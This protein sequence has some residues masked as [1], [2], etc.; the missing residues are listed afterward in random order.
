MARL[1]AVGVLVALYVC[2]STCTS[3]LQFSGVNSGVNFVEDSHH[4]AALGI[5]QRALFKGKSLFSGLILA[6]E[7]CYFYLKQ[8]NLI[9]WMSVELNVSVLLL[10]C[11]VRSTLHVGFIKFPKRVHGAQAV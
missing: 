8:H 5:H 6:M 10:H 9:F 3:A 11:P 2:A 7:R 1:G 4:G